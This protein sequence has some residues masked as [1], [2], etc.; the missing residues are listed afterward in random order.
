MSTQKYL[1]LWFWRMGAPPQ[2]R[3]HFAKRIARMAREYL[4]RAQQLEPRLCWFEWD[5]RPP[6]LMTCVTTKIF[7]QMA[8]KT[9]QQA[10]V[11]TQLKRITHVA[12]TSSQQLK[13][14]ITWIRV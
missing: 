13:R 7:N 8:K 14:K 9:R 6:Q 11:L 4:W 10:M 1:W 12:D 3:R 5:T 2:I